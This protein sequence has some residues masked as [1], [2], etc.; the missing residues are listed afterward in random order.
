MDEQGWVIHLIVDD[1]NFPNNTNHHTHGL[2]E[3][4]NHFNLQI[5]LNLELPLI[6]QIFN[7]AVRNIEKGHIYE[8][9]TWHENICLNIKVGFMLSV[10]D[11][12]P[13]LRLLI[14]DENGAFEAPGYKDQVNPVNI[15]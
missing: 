14:P 2:Q 7:I 13:V 4:F 5:C 6:C 9:G 3:K 8:A 11:G 15:W 12:E 1:E 10:N